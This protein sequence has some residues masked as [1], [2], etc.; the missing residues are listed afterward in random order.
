MSFKV[1]AACLLISA[2]VFGQDKPA[3]DSGRT[4]YLPG[5]PIVANKKSLEIVKKSIAEKAA[6]LE[7]LYARLS[8]MPIQLKLNEVYRAKDKI[9]IL[10]DNRGDILDGNQVY[11][12]FNYT[13][14]EF[15]SGKIKN[16]RHVNEKENYYNRIMTDYKVLSIVPGQE[17]S[18]IVE[19]RT[20]DK[21]TKSEYKDFSGETRFYTLKLVE[22]QLR[23]AIS[24]VDTILRRNTLESDRKTVNSLG[25][26]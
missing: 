23:L 8:S 11:N 25:G 24:K 15:A 12:N 16:I 9:I 10:N 6:E 22:N 1:V 5:N 26:I 17:E 7:N 2:S 19:V 4:N 20:I 18:A 14:Y 21:E 13:E 3:G